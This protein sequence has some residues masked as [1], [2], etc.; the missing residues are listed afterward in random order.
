MNQTDVLVVSA[1]LTG[2]DLPNGPDLVP[3]FLDLLR[4]VE[5][6][7]DRIGVTNRI[8]D[9][10]YGPFGEEFRG[11]RQRRG[12]PAELTGLANEVLEQQVDGDATY[13][14][15]GTLF[16]RLTLEDPTL[17]PR[18][19]A[20]VGSRRVTAK[21]R[22]PEGAADDVALVLLGWLKTH[23]RANRVVTGF[24]HV[25]VEGDPYSERIVKRAGLT[26]NE[27]DWQI[28]GY[29]WAILLTSGH[30]R[31]IDI[32]DLQRVDGAQVDWIDEDQMAL[33]RAAAAPS[34][35]T[36][37]TI[38]QWRSVLR[39]LLREGLPILDFS[40]VPGSRRY[41]DCGGLLSPAQQ[42]QPR[43]LAEGP[44]VPYYRAS[45][46]GYPGTEPPVT[47]TDR[48]AE[49]VAIVDVVLE[50][51]PGFDELLCLELVRGLAFAWYVVWTSRLAQPDHG[52]ITS[53]SEPRIDGATEPRQI[54]WS[55]RPGTADLDIALIGLRSGLG[56]L[57]A[58]FDSSLFKRMRIS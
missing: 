5:D 45:L 32:A 28:H 54:Q 22:V 19:F 47:L 41:T 13:V 16:H 2:L 38:R 27:F 58:E 9:W 49:G 40:V 57:Q 53:M 48:H 43:W 12:Q 56:Q 52:A 31:M 24:V 1:E 17:D 26:A 14:T 8:Q 46:F 23:A 35:L 34:D 15:I 18:S 6:M 25:D 42:R 3:A 21:L 39:P 44:P 37:S 30:L 36:M 51:A 4:V 50:L 55:F 33:V 7:I 29:Y 20:G 10:S 11:Y